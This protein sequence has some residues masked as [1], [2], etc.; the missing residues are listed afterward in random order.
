MTAKNLLKTNKNLIFVSNLHN[1]AKLTIKNL[2][3]FC[4]SSSILVD[5]FTW[6][7]SFINPLGSNSAFMANKL[8][9]CIQ[10]SL[11][12]WYVSV[13]SIKTIKL[14]LKKYFWTDLNKTRYAQN[15]Y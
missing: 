9:S 5:D 14:K 4:N 2:K 15:T 10:S 13:A 1:T 12:D 7:D 11:F 3:Y 6:I 8:G